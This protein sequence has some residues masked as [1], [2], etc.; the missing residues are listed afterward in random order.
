M[1]S[2]YFI[3]TLFCVVNIEFPFLTEMLKLLLKNFGKAAS[4][5]FLMNGERK[6]FLTLITLKILPQKQTMIWRRHFIQTKLFPALIC[7]QQ[8]SSNNMSPPWLFVSPFSYKPD[9]FFNRL[10][11]KQLSLKGR[12]RVLF[13]LVMTLL[14][15][16]A[17]QK[18]KI[19]K[20]CLK[21]QW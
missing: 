12:K 1:S 5:I 9:Y 21:T 17:V 13:N 7:N 14:L 20:T 15:P 4:K 3:E 2:K 6:A 11:F 18:W 8:L 19:R 10:F 16:T